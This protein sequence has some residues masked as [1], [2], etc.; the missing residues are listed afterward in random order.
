MQLNPN[1]IWLYQ[2]ESVRTYFDVCSRPALMFVPG[3]FASVLSRLA[4][5]EGFVLK[6]MLFIYY[7][8]RSCHISSFCLSFIL[9]FVRNVAVW[10][11][12]SLPCLSVF[13]HFVY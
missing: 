9:S 4:K 3:E 13:I 2:K 8:A 10:L 7:V 5:L 11:S 12:I 1:R 6:T